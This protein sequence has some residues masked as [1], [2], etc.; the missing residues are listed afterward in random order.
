MVAWQRQIVTTCWLVA[1]LLVGGCAAAPARPVASATPKAKIDADALAAE[2]RSDVDALPSHYVRG[3][4]TL[5]HK[6]DPI[7]EVSAQ[8]ALD[9]AH[10]LGQMLTRPER[11]KIGCLNTTDGDRVICSQVGDITMTLWFVHDDVGIRLQV[12]SLSV[13]VH[14]PPM[15]DA[16]PLTQPPMILFP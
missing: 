16:R 7:A 10:K 13:P 14:E 15:I 3:S 8:V 2:L 1:S 5:D 4:F 9:A 6:Q 11:G 12:A